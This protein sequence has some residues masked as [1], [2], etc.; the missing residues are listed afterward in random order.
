MIHK[1]ISC[2]FVFLMIK[3]LDMKLLYFNEHRFCENYTAEDSLSFRCLDLKKGE[4]I[5]SIEKTSNYLFFV[6]KGEIEVLCNEY[7]KVIKSGELILIPKSSESAVRVLNNANIVIH[8][9]DSLL[10]LCDRYAIEKLEI[11]ASKVKYDFV[12]SKIAE[13]LYSFLDLLT[14]YLD[15]KMLCRHMQEIKQ[16]E[17]FMLFRAFYTKEECATI[18]YPLL[19]SNM[20]FKN[21]VLDNYQKAKRVQDLANLC[22]LSLTTFN[23]KFRLFFKDSPYNWMLKQKAKHI[24]MKLRNSNIPICDIIEEYGFS[25]SGHF[26]SYC[27]THFNMTP[28]QLRKKLSAEKLG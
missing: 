13:P 24:Q 25:S 8:V 5:P 1:K 10:N 26:T 23:R 2:N 27:K 19:S 16:T 11:Y 21:M 15:E 28:T 12:P 20:D 18:F 22:C 6:R 7:R 4:I 9:F 3:L 14:F 17:M